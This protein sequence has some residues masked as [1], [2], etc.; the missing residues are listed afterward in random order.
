MLASPN[1]QKK[2][3]PSDFY[4]TMN[5]DV[6]S[7]FVD[8]EQAEKCA[9]SRFR[10]FRYSRERTVLPPLGLTKQHAYESEELLRL[11]E[12]CRLRGRPRPVCRNIFYY[13]FYPPPPS[14][15][16]TSFKFTS[17]LLQIYISYILTLPFQ[18]K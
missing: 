16:P 10:S 9:C 12:A 2:H 14:P 1:Y 4:D 13:V 17:I 3:V 6:F 15:L 8:L 11:L 7:N 18:R 5:F